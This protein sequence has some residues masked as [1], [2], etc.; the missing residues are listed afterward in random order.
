MAKSRFVILLFFSIL[1]TTSSTTNTSSNKNGS[2]CS[3]AFCGAYASCNANNT[4]TCSCLDGFIPKSPKDWEKLVFSGGCVR[5]IPINCSDK[6]VFLNHSGVI[7]PEESSCWYNKSVSVKECENLCSRNCSCTAYAHLDPRKGENGCLLWFN[8]LIHVIRPGEEDLFVRVAASE[9]AQIQKK[10]STINKKETGIIAGTLLAVIVTPMIFYVCRRNVRKYASYVKRMT[11]ESH[12]MDFIKNKG[13]KEDMELL[14]FDFST[15]VKATDNFSSNNML[16]KGG[17]GPVYKGTFADGQEIAVKRLSEGSGQGMTEFKNEV[18]LISKLQH[19]NLVKLIGCCIQKDEQML[20]YE[21]MPNKS[22]DYFIFDQKRSNILDWEKRFHIIG[23]IARGLLY[24]HQDSRLRI[25]HR[26]L[27]ASNVLLDKDMNPKISDF[28]MARTFR[29]DQTEANTNR[30]AGTYGYMPPEYAVDGLFSMKSDVFSYGVLV[31]E[32]VS[33]KKNRGFSHPDHNLNLLGHAWKL[34]IEER[35][36]EL[37]DNTLDSYSIREA[38]RCIHVGLLCV[39]QRP[40]ERPSMSTVVVMLSSDSAL[41]QPKQPGFFTE[42]N[43]PES[44]SSVSKHGSSS[45]NQISTTLI[46][47]R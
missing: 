11:R 7:V 13:G 31:L 6:V 15:I 37:V 39:Q 28:G 46:E 22:L 43:M 1:T 5:R 19:R 42:R 17:F 40:E 21:F 23:G 16:G 3:Y 24:L 41:P 38:L 10:R 4:P 47:P 14:I 34:W 44:E 12:I 9:L 18:T 45:R 25:I 27:K 30:V 36:S 8:E 33:G 2:Q 26:D 35:S 29:G 32:I 20:I